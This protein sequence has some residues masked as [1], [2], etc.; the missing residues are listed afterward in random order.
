MTTRLLC[1]LAT[2][3]HAARTTFTTSGRTYASVDGRT[4]DVADFD[5]AAGA[6]NGFALIAPVGPTSARPPL[7][8]NDGP[9]HYLDSS[10]QKIVVWGGTGFIDPATGAAV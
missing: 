7:T 6:S 5:A 3:L 2:P 10:L 8:A 9:L 4:I 1:P